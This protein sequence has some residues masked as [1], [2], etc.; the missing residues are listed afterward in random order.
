M[1]IWLPTQTGQNAWVS[2]GCSLSGSGPT[3]TVTCTSGYGTN[4]T[5]SNL[6][7][8]QAAGSLYL[9]GYN[10]TP[11]SITVSAV[12]PGGSTNIQDTWS[13]GYLDAE[14]FNRG[15]QKILTLL[16]AIK[17][18]HFNRLLY[19]SNTNV[20]TAGVG[21]LVS[22]D[23]VYVPWIWQ[24]VGTAPQQQCAGIEI[25][26]CGCTGFT[27]SVWSA[28]TSYLQINSAAS[29]TQLVNNLGI[30][31]IHRTDGYGNIVTVR[32]LT[33]K[34][35]NA[36]AAVPSRPKVNYADCLPG[37]SGSGCTTGA[38]WSQL[39]PYT[40]VAGILSAGTMVY[41]Q[42]IVYAN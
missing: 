20:C 19:E 8:T 7:N 33:D 27:S 15:N 6:Q 25:G 35:G 2:A 42:K 21:G 38:V 34:S 28:S 3:Y 14:Y 18:F 10:K 23:D 24:I 30:D 9:N 11:Y 13:S 4:F 32:L 36:L 41:S 22:T 5:F 31:A 1:D 29:L 39:P 40:G 12:I 26:P 16:R 17:A 37:G